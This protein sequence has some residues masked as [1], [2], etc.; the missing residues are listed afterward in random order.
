MLHI[1]YFNIL[2]NTLYI[3]IACI[4]GELVR[5]TLFKIHYEDVRTM[6]QEMSTEV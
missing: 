6:F 5:T 3:A 4:R 1:V 2:Q